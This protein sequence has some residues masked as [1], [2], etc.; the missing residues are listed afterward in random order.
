MNH[1]DINQT[2]DLEYRDFLD[3][4]TKRYS[5]RDPLD[6]LKYAFKLFVGDDPSGKITVRALKK[7]AR[8][9]SENVNEEDLEQMIKEFDLDNDGMSELISRRGELHQNHDRRHLLIT[10]LSKSPA[11]DMAEWSKALH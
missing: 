2:G 5:E 8:D 3:Y 9:L 7:I 11:D 6:E 10:L 1:Y 4:M